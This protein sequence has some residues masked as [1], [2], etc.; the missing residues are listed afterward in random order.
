[1]LENQKQLITGLLL[2]QYTTIKVT[3]N[4]LIRED[5]Y[6]LHSNTGKGSEAKRTEKNKNKIE[7]LKACQ[8]NQ[9]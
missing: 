6:S 9:F 3:K 1:M 7:W 4:I 5:F 8:F 2:I